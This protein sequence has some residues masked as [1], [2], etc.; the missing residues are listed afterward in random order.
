MSVQRTVGLIAVSC[1]WNAGLFTCEIF[2]PNPDT[3][4]FWLSSARHTVPHAGSQKWKQPKDLHSIMAP[5]LVYTH[6]HFGMYKETG[7]AYACSTF[8][9]KWV[10]A[11]GEERSHFFRARPR[12]QLAT[13]SRSAGGQNIVPAI[14]SAKATTIHHYPRKG[15]ISHKMEC[16]VD[17][18]HTQ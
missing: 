18:S 8:R 10:K 3:E 17:K 4:Y 15:Q 2:H 13:A 1:G 14:I 7:M 16:P 11:A 9:H 6:T 5:S 12:R